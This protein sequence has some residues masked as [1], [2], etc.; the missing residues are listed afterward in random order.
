MNWNLKNTFKTTNHILFKF[1]VDDII[2]IILKRMSPRDTQLTYCRGCSALE[3]LVRWLA[4]CISSAIG[5][6]PG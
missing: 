4:E 2:V 5:L 3:S 6:L 1:Q